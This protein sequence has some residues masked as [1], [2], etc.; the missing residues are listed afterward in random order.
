[1]EIRVL[2]V[3]ESLTVHEEDAVLIEMLEHF[4][5]HLKM[6]EATY[7]EKDSNDASAN[8]SGVDAQGAPERVCKR[9][10]SNHSFTE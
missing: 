2:K 9:F 3:C 10:Q 7:V 4:A 8:T 1:M 5:G 6:I